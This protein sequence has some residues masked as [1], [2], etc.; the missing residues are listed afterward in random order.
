MFKRLIR[1]RF[2]NA[3]QI[4]PREEEGVEAKEKGDPGK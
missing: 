3:K 4:Y 2:L 1:K